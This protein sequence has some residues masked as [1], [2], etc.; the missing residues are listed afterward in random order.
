MAALV[1]PSGV[2]SGEYLADQLLE[3]VKRGAR[4]PVSQATVEDWEILRTADLKVRD[5]LVPLLVSVGEDYMVTEADVP[6]VAGRTD[7]YAPARSLKLR[8]VQFLDSRG[9]ETDVPRLR[10]DG[11]EHR[12]W[13]VK[14]YGSTVRVVEPERVGATA[15]RFAYYL[16]PSALVKADAVSVVQAIDRVAGVVDLYQVPAGI[17]GGTTFDFVNARAPFDCFAMDVAGTVDAAGLK[18]TF[19]PG[20][21][22]VD[23]AVGDFVCLPEQTPVPQIAP[24][25]H[26]LLKQAVVLELLDEQGDEG[27]FA[28]AEK[29]LGKLDADARVVLSS[30][31]EGEPFP[32]AVEDPIWDRGWT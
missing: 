3:D 11:E 16:R 6:I 26:P 1:L 32:I 2:T 25:L 19:A 27:A 29:K 10:F 21:L 15:I 22:P 9:R 30:R 12:E 31:V 4:M 8:E 28:R 23:L 7:Y 20:A 5:Y 18:I 17:T 14:L 13:G 24:E